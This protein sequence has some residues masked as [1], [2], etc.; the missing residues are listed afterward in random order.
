MTKPTGFTR[1]SARAMLLATAA[2]LLA[3][4]APAQAANE[5]IIAIF[6]SLSEPFFVFMQRAALDIVLRTHHQ[7]AKK[8]AEADA[9]AALF[10]RREIRQLVTLF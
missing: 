2:C 4:V 6:N 7:A 9:G 10:G 5:R 8:P 3:G 1:R